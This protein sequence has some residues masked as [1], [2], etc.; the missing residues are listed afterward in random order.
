MR[1]VRAGH[2]QAVAENRVRR[3][4]AEGLQ[5][6]SP[7]DLQVLVDGRAAVM[8]QHE[9]FGADGRPL[10]HHAR[11]A[12][13]EKERH[14]AG[15]ASGNAAIDAYLGSLGGE[16]ARVPRARNANWP[17]RAAFA[18]TGRGT[19]A[20]RRQVDGRVRAAVRPTAAERDVDAHPEARG[21]VVGEPHVVQEFIGEIRK[22]AA[23]P[24]TR[25]RG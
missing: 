4:L 25:S 20:R 16:L 15:L 2:F 9:A 18:G 14:A 6:R 12:G 1:P 10:H 24:S 8:V 11:A 23:L 13:N 5:Q 17:A 7:V 19:Q 21:L 22:C 3:V